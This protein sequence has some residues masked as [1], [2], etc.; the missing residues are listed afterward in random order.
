MNLQDTITHRMNKVMNGYRGYGIEPSVMPEAVYVD[1]VLN[2]GEFGAYAMLKQPF[3]VNARRIEALMRASP[4]TFGN[5]G[6]ELTAMLGNIFTQ[7]VFRGLEQVKGDIFL[8][9]PYFDLEEKNAEF[10]LAHEV[11]HYIENEEGVLNE[12]PLINEGTATYAAS[13]ITGLDMSKPITS[14]TEFADVIYSGA[15]HLV[16]VHA[17]SAPNPLAV[18]LNMSFREYVQK[19]FSEDFDIFWEKKRRED[20]EQKSTLMDRLFQKCLPTYSYLHSTG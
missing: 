16:G 5:F 15:S 4:K 20:E 2:F 6:E 13:L 12:H 17:H 18:L 9:R 14:C 11:W 1:N 7:D 3:G 19:C 8:F 10:T